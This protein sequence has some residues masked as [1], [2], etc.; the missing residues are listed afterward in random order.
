MT[1]PLQAIMG[2]IFLLLVG[3]TLVAV[4]YFIMLVGKIIL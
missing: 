4:I 1:V 2:F 3:G